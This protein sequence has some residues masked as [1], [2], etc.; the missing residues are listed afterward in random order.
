MLK[1]NRIAET[2]KTRARKAQVEAHAN[3]IVEFRAKEGPG[4]VNQICEVVQTLLPTMVT[5]LPNLSAN[6]ISAIIQGPVAKESASVTTRVAS[7]ACRTN[8]GTTL[9]NDSTDYAAL[10]VM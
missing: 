3:S 4:I 8:L 7:N 10:S 6:S 1:E 5:P 9:E 2:V